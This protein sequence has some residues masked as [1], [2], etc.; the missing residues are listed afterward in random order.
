MTLRILLMINGAAWT[1]AFAAFLS[2]S[3]ID[4]IAIGDRTFAVK[5]RFCTAEAY[6]V[7]VSC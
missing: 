1:I 5:A 7:V 6:V 2:V 3:L 4:G